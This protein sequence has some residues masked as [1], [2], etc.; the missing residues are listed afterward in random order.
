MKNQIEVTDREK[1]G[2]KDSF[3]TAEK[4]VMRI[5][6][7]I[8]IL[9]GIVGVFV[10]NWIVGVIYLVFVIFSLEVLLLRMFCSYCPYPYQYSTCLFMPLRNF[11]GIDQKQEK[12]PFINRHAP[13]IA[14]AGMYLIPQYWIVRNLFFFI[15]FWVFGLIV[16]LGLIIHFCGSCRH[17][18]CAMNRAAKKP[19]VA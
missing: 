8:F 4:L 11:K 17:V 16:G 14:F 6:F 12:M 7:F 5:S 3:S 18:Q 13:A 1:E 15:G 9:F 2:F 19:Y 10:A